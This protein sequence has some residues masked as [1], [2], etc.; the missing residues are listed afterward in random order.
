MQL[1]GLLIHLI[2]NHIPVLLPVVG[3]A[4]LAV[5]FVI[6]LRQTQFVGLTLIVIGALATIPTY[7]SGTFAKNIAQ[8]YALVTPQSIEVHAQAALYSFIAIEIVGCLGLLFI[9]LGWKGAVLPQKGLIA[10][11]MLTMLASL[12]IARTAHLGGLIRH[13]ELEQGIF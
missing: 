9:Y 10:F 3:T 8:N 4:V 13:E 1:N 11:I 2:F 12:L 5:G 6:K 7:Y